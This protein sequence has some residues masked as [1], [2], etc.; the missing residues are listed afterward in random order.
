MSMKHY[1]TKPWGIEFL[2]VEI[3]SYRLK[4]IHVDK[5]CRTSLHYHQ[6]K[7]ETIFKLTFNINDYHHI[8]PMERHRLEEGDYFEVSTGNDFDS[9]RIEDDFKRKLG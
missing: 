6:T 9:V 4:F 7:E 3:E 2:L 8:K 1:Q 5:G